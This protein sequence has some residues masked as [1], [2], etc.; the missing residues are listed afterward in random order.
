M[1]I[2]YLVCPSGFLM[3]GLIQHSLASGLVMAPYLMPVCPLSELQKLRS[4]PR[5]SEINEPGIKIIKTNLPV[6]FR[7][8]MFIVMEHKVSILLIS[9]YPCN[10]D[11]TSP[12][13]FLISIS[14]TSDV[15]FNFDSQVIFTYKTNLSKLC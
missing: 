4:Y 6:I 11:T 7:L 9:G 8:I 15:H 3:F 5:Y 12:G 13:K 14:C 10:V 1:P 2:I